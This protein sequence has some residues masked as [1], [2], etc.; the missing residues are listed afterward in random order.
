MSSPSS[1][2]LQLAACLF[3]LVSL[4]RGADAAAPAVPTVNLSRVEDAQYFHI[5]FGQSFKV[6]KNSID[7]KSYLLMQVSLRS[8]LSFSTAGIPRLSNC[9]IPLL[10]ST[11]NIAIYIRGKKC[12]SSAKKFPVP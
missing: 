8:P 2:L 9:I 6:I 1:K 5:Y 7:G 11:S 12:S 4:L 10:Y 3:S